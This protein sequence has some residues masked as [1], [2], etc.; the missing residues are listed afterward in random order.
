MFG[1]FI[2]KFGCIILSIWFVAYAAQ[3]SAQLRLFSN[4][5]TD[6]GLQSNNIYCILEDAKGHI[7]TGSFGAGVSIY[8]GVEFKGFTTV[9]GLNSNYIRTLLEDSQGRI[10]IGTQRGVNRFTPAGQLI[11]VMDKEEVFDLAEDEKGAVWMAT[12]HGVYKMV[13]D[14]LIQCKGITNSIVFSLFHDSSHRTWAGPR[15]LGLFLFDESANK[16]LKYPTGN[17]L[18]NQVIKD[19]IEL[20]DGR[21]LIAT[22]QSLYEMLP[23]GEINK[24]PIHAVIEDLFDGGNFIWASTF[25]NGIIRLNKDGIY[26][27]ISVENGLIS[28]NIKEIIRDDENNIWIASNEAGIARSLGADMYLIPSS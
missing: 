20:D 25:K 10:W 5:D 21:I 24:F 4:L 7:W 22:N 27:T 1:H 23:S 28:N 14:S 3:S 6:V 8:N 18:D 15:G 9:D 2:N 13:D 17:L 12:T 11:S 19:M 16:F 26:D